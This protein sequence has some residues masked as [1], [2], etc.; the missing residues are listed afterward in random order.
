MAWDVEGCERMRQAARGP[1]ACS[2]SAISA[3]T[4]RCTR[5]PTRAS[6]RPARSATSTLAHRLAPQ[7]QLAPQGRPA[8]ARLRSVA[9]GLQGLRAPAQLAPLQAVLARA[10]G[11][12]RQPPGQHR[13][14]VLRRRARGRARHGGVDRALKDGREVPDH[15]FATFEYPGGRTATFSSIESNAFDHYYEAFFGT[16]GTLHAQGRDGGVPLRRGR[17][18]RP[19]GI[20]VT[21]RRR[22]PGARSLGEP[23]RPTRPAGRSGHGDRRRDRLLAYRNEISG[24][25]AAIRTGAPLACGPDKA[26]ARPSPASARSRPATRRR[27]LHA[28]RLSSVP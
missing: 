9:V 25:C 11:R 12:A 18:P 3:S 1:T 2:R 20:E 19:T 24:F 10:A 4:T 23:R 8:D 15:V 13:Q 21:P 28:W 17:R 5:R 14:L 16:K 26:M 6:S 22:R 7:R 27:A